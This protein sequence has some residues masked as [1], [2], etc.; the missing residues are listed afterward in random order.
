[1]REFEIVRAYDL[2]S[3]FSVLAENP[4]AKVIAGGTNLV[5]LMKLGV[6]RPGTLVDINGMKELNG[7]DFTDDGGVIIGA[8]TSN[9][10]LAWHSQIQSRLPMI[11]QS[12]LA[13]AT[14][15]IRNMATVGGNLLQKNRCPYFADTGARCNKRD[16]GSGCEALQGA[17]RMC[18]VLGVSN[19]CI[20]AHPSDLCVALTALDAVIHASSSN[21]ARQ[22]PIA[23]F[24]KRP[25]DTPSVENELGEAELITAIQIPALPFAK[26]STY[27]KLRD[28]KSYAF[29]LVSVAAA[30]SHNNGHIENIR[31]ALG[32]VG[33]IPWRAKTAE[34]LLCGT[35]PSDKDLRN[36]AEAVFEEATPQSGNAFKIELAQRAI[37]R[38]LRELLE[39]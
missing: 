17:N 27:A 4:E 20:A 18:A 14:T 26:H 6:E 25:G 5:D 24:Y 2:P 33:S 12:I 28:R 29:A 13:G 35:T 34:Q 3:L 16:P 21:G 38:V 23:E 32:S 11:S 19:K 15:Q 37:V 36:A 7:I 8:L 1:M 39:A 10:E 31:L 22:I 9:S 30:V